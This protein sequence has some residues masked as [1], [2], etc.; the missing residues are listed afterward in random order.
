[1][2]LYKDNKWSSLQMLL[3]DILKWLSLVW[4][5]WWGGCGLH[6]GSIAGTLSSE[7]FLWTLR[8]H[9]NQ[10]RARLGTAPTL[11][12]CHMTYY[13]ILTHSP[14]DAIYHTVIQTRP[15]LGYSLILNFHSPKLIQVCL[16]KGLYFPSFVEIVSQSILP[17]SQKNISMQRFTL[18][19]IL[20]I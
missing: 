11:P 4:K 19:Y 6:T 17:T 3:K 18:S 16:V 1:M 9:K 12:S 15:S 8:F 2:L 13:Y 14:H 7:G 10:F 20:Q 5:L